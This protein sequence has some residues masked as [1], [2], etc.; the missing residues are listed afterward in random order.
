MQRTIPMKK[1]FPLLTICCL[2]TLSAQEN[3]ICLTF[4]TNRKFVLP[5]ENDDYNRFS[6]SSSKYIPH[7]GAYIQEWTADPNEIITVIH[8]K[9]KGIK[10]C[11]LEVKMK[12][13]A[14]NLY[15]G[16]DYSLRIVQKSKG[17]IILISEA[18]QGHKDIP[19]FTVVMRHVSTPNADQYIV[20]EK[21]NGT[22]SQS[23]KE[24]WIDKLKQAYVTNSLEN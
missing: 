10:S 11:Q 22:L 14:R 23:E 4:N 16:S 1:L 9:K 13:I 8:E 6:H 20:Y 12:E 18:P 7:S 15:A 19:P 17:D 3:K 5:L 21:R 2:M 24:E